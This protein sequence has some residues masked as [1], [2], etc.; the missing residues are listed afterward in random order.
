MNGAKEWNTFIRTYTHTIVLPAD[1]SGELDLPSDFGWMIDQTGW[2]PTNRLPLGG[3]LSQADW[4]FILNTNLG[5]STIF[6]S[7]QQSAGKLC[8]LPIPPPAGSIIN[9]RYVSDGWVE[10]GSAPGTYKNKATQSAD[11]VRFPPILMSK[12]LKLRFLEAK[13]FDTTA[14]SAQFANVWG[15]WAPKDRAADVLSVS[16]NRNYPYLGWRNIPE[17]LYG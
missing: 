13:G 4:T 6:V 11:I 1:N 17:T 9:F 7:F 10:S 14:A 15:I 5:Q 2:N 12:F 3:P 16:R 8:L